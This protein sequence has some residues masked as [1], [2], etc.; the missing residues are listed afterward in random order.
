V[1]TDARQTYLGL[2]Y[3][4]LVRSSQ[5][6]VSGLLPPVLPV[7]L[8][9]GTEVWN[10]AL[11][12]EAL[13][14]PAPSMLD[15]YRPRQGYLV[16]D[17]RRVARAGRLP[18]RNLSAALFRL[19]AS[20]GPAEVTAIVHALLDW[21]KAPEQAGFRRAFAVWLGR[22][23]LPRRPSGIAIAPMSDLFEVQQM[24]SEQVESWTEQWKN[25]GLERGLAQGLEQGLEQG[26]EQGMA[27]GR[28]ETRHLLA[29]L[30]RRR[31]G[32]AIAAEAVP[33]MEGI[34]DP[35]V[36]EA[37]GDGLLI[38]PDGETWLQDLRRAQP[39]VDQ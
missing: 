23:F 24:L 31:F 20:R 26:R 7:V 1:S 25:E 3:Q 30:A 28:Q 13:I 11:Q 17:E 36:L 21:L 39:S 22:V 2:L 33:L 38:S 19:E 27:L 32:P 35:H 8:Y 34:V 15:A 4:D 10:S 12:I 16:I 5:L 29:R 14:E 18:E 6:S 37:I 9:N